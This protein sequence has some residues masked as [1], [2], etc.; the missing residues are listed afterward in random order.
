M[1][2][3]WAAWH[4]CLLHLTCL[5]WLVSKQWRQ[6]LCRHWWRHLFISRLSANAAAADDDDDDDKRGDVFLMTLSELLLV[7]PYSCAVIGLHGSQW[8][9]KKWTPVYFIQC[10]LFSTNQWNVKAKIYFIPVLLIFM[11]LHMFFMTQ[12]VS[13]FLLFKQ[14]N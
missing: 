13:L 9:S 12:F 4:A 8:W 2:Y 6:Y 11:H 1:C 5:A 10:L 14:K 7:S 3:F